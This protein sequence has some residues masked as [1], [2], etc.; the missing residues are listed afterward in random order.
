M[1]SRTVIDIP[2]YFLIG[3]V[4]GVVISMSKFNHE[5]ETV[6]LKSM[7]FVSV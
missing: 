6:P 3:L 7:L 2:I 4:N 1:E 5:P